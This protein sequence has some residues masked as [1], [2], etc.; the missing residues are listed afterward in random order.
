MNFQCHWLINPF[1]FSVCCAGYPSPL[2]HMIPGFLPSESVASVY[3][4]DYKTS[5]AMNVN[6]G[7]LRILQEA[8]CKRFL[9]ESPIKIRCLV[10]FCYRLRVAIWEKDNDTMCWLRGFNLLVPLFL[11]YHILIHS[12]YGF[13]GAWGERPLDLPCGPPCGWLCR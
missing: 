8:K 3:K 13:D 5:V 4:C 2:H 12:K 11:S 9:L 10:C 1:T 6:K 7:N